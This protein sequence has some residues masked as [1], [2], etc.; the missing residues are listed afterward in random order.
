M[1]ARALGEITRSV[2]TIGETE[3]AKKTSQKVHY[4]ATVACSSA[5]G[6]SGGRIRR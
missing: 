4:F 2:V 6:N 3:R 1:G 5:G